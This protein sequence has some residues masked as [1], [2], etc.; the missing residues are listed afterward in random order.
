MGKTV[1]EVNDFGKPLSVEHFNLKSKSLGK[2]V[3]TYDGFGR[4]T[5]QTD[6]VGNTTRYEYDVFDRMIRT[7]LPDA[8]AVVTDYAEHS[9]EGLPIGIKVDD[10]V[11][12]QQTYDGLSRLIQ[13]TVGGRKSEAGYEAGFTQPQWHKSADGKKPIHL[14]GASGRFAEERKAGALVTTMTY[15]P[16]SGNPLTCTENG[17]ERSLPITFRTPQMRNDDLRRYQESH[18][19]YL[20]PAGA[21]DHPCRCA[22]SRKQIRIR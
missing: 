12:G 6:P 9:D 1:T 5:S 22:R 8:S 14:F 20:F 3:Y 19:Q 16:V 7:V 21:N 13:S 11:L 4:T 2:T 18:V 15:D 10:K 17:K